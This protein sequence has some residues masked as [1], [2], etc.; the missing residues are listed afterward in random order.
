MKKHKASPASG[1][2][3]VDVRPKWVAY[4]ITVQRRL[5]RLHFRILSNIIQRHIQRTKGTPIITGNQREAALSI[6]KV[7]FYVAVWTR[8]DVSTSNAQPTTIPKH[9]IEGNGNANVCAVLPRRY[10]HERIPA[11]I[12]DLIR[13]GLKR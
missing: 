10:P 4:W 6:G 5:Q 8:V 2:T 3:C 9:L 11:C 12:C 7:H 13:P 1:I